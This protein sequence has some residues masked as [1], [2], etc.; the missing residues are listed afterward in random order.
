GAVGLAQ[1]NHDVVD[2][3]DGEDQDGGVAC[4][5]VGLGDVGGADQPGAAVRLEGAGRGVAGGRAGGRRRGGGR[6][7]GAE[8]RVADRGGG[9]VGDDKG[10]GVVGADEGTEG[11]VAVAEDEQDVAEF[12][13]HHEVGLAVV[14]HV[15]DGQAAG[16][17]AGK[18]TAQE[19]EAAVAQ[20]FV[21]P[22]LAAV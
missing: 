9:R 8:R 13:A 14:V 10:D 5:E 21:K 17:V 3:G 15:I 20:S 7:R 2:G 18:D 6:A 12:I 16:S 11:A 22:H 19:R 1:V 4:I